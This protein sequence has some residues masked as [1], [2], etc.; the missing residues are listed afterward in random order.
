[1]MMVVV[2]VVVCL[3]QNGVAMQACYSERSIQQENE[4]VKRSM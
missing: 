4:I 3:K 2:V 1:M